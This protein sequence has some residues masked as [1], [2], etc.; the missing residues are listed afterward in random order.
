MPGN[1]SLDSDD[2]SKDRYFHKDSGKKDEKRSAGSFERCTIQVELVRAEGLLASMSRD[3]A[4]PFVVIRAGKH[5]KS[6]KSAV[7]KSTLKPD[8]KNEKLRVAWDGNKKNSLRVIVWDA[9]GSTKHLDESLGHVEINL[10]GIQHDQEAQAGQGVYVKINLEDYDGPPKWYVEDVVTEE[11]AINGGGSGFLSTLT[12]WF[13]GGH[14]YIRISHHEGVD[15]DLL[16][17]EKGSNK[18]TK[19]KR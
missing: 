2:L 8:F 7:Y 5:T 18:G 19:A 15:D 3:T 1:A 14:L 9:Q 13:F 12:H 17:E 10:D 6:V 11:E 4:D 16:E